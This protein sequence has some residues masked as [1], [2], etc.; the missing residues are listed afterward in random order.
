DLAGGRLET[1]DRVCRPHDQLLAPAR[2]DDDGRA[3]GGP[4][5]ERLPALLPGVPVEGND[6]RLGLAAG[7]DDEQVTHDQGRRAGRVA[8]NPAA[9]ILDQ[10]LLPNDCARGRVE[11]EQ[12]PFGSQRVDLAVVYRGRGARAV[13]VFH[14]LV[15]TRIGM[16]PERLA[17]GFVEAEDALDLLSGPAVGN[18]DPALSN[19]RP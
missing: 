18:E 8:L 13:A 17:R 7:A 11:A 14:V 6:A 2:G 3:V 16:H 12:M 10:A 9:E 5:L 15:V 19:H 1:G 4:V